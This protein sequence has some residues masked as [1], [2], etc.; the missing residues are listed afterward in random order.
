MRTYLIRGVIFMYFLRCAFFKC[1]VK[2]TNVFI[3]CHYFVEP[4]I[5]NHL[6]YLNTHVQKVVALAKLI[7]LGQSSW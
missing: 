2:L 5:L 7:S 6:I 3:C 1:M 4:N